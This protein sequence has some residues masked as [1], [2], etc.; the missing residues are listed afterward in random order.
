[1]NAFDAEP[2]VLAAEDVAVHFGGIKA[3][4]G[5]GLNLPAGRICGILGPN[6]SGK[7]TFLAAVTRLVSLTRGRLL[8]DG[9]EYQN[10]PPETLARRG[11]SRTFQT[12]RLLPDLTVLENVRLGADLHARGRG[13][14]SWFRPDTTPEV[15]DEAIERTGLGTARSWR[16]GELSYGMARRVEIARAL[17]AKPR[18]LLLDE[19]TAGMNQRERGEISELLRTLRGDGLAQLLVEHDVQMMVDTCDHLVAMNFGALAAEGTPADVVVHPA[20]QEAYLGKRG[21]SHA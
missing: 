10:A 4:D 9:A 2:A 13:V 18:V 3:V 15:V 21:R 5:F 8:L 16:P 14:R 7:S 17:A 6:G 19:P 20:V 11:L 12:V 1:M